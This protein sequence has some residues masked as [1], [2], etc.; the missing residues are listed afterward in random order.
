MADQAEYLLAL[1]AGTGNFKLMSYGDEAAARQAAKRLWCNWV[2]FRK[3]ADG[4]A[5]ELSAGGVG[6][7]VP[8]IRRWAAQALAQ[9]A[10]DTNARAGAAAAAEARAAAAAARA[11]A[12]PKP[13]APTSN[14]DGRVDVSNPVVWD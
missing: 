13:A 7:A 5:A 3:G 8:G 4:V 14:N 1:E 10:R 9:K 12:R 11:P 6:F 2:L